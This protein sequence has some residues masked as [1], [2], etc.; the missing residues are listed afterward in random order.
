MATGGLVYIKERFIIRLYGASKQS[1]IDFVKTPSQ[2]K[3]LSFVEFLEFFGRLAFWVVELDQSMKY[4]ELELHERIDALLAHY[5]KNKGISGMLSS[6]KEDMSEVVDEI[7][8]YMREFALREVM[9]N[10]E[11]VNTGNESMA[12][13]SHM[14]PSVHVIN[15]VTKS[16]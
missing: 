13:G 5:C 9:Q 8:E 4:H 2:S 15:D 6:L 10:Q 12:S 7:N 3:E 16:K 14:E 1:V 11:S